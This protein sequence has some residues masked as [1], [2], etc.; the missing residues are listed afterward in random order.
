MRRVVLK[1]HQRPA[2]HVHVEVPHC[3]AV[4]TVNGLAASGPL[5]REQAAR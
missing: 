3:L 1:I 2:F 4:E 5:L